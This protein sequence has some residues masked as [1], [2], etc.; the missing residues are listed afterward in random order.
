[1]K[2]IRSLALL[3]ARATRAILDHASIGEFRKRFLE[4]IMDILEVTIG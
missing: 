3:C 1:M 2:H 4:A